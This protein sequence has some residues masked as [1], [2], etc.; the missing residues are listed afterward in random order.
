MGRKWD[1]ICFT[2]TIF[3]V[4]YVLSFAFY[5][6]VKAE[7]VNE[8]I[9]GGFPSQKSYQMESS[10]MSEAEKKL[11]S[12]LLELIKALELQSSGKPV[13]NSEILQ[14]SNFIS[15]DPARGIDENLVY[16]YISLN[17]TNNIEVIEPFV[18]EIT[19]IDEENS[20]LV[21][22]VSVK[23]LEELAALD[24]VRNIRTV[25]SPVVNVNDSTIE[26]NTKANDTENVNYLED[27]GW[28]K[29]IGIIAFTAILFKIRH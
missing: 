19:N 13:I 2:G 14:T 26:V 8:T 3:V 21:A 1:L 20:V 16:V 27:S 23:N 17:K 4:V 5:P 7:D 9:V 15:A 11:S 10:N 6:V 28:I 25:V 24:E 22:W 29:L 12:D 18:K